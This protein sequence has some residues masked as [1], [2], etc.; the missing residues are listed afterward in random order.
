MTEHL[1]ALGPTRTAVPLRPWWH[2][3]GGTGWVALGLC[4]FAGFVCICSRGWVVQSSQGWVVGMRPHVGDGSS[5]VAWWWLE[6]A[7]AAVGIIGRWLLHVLREAEC[8]IWHTPT[9]LPF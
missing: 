8:H 3:V 9:V 4:C 5:K 6:N 2:H 7:S 1:R